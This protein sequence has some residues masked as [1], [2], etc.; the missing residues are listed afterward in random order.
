MGIEKDIRFTQKKIDESWKNE[1]NKHAAAP[2]PARQ[3]GTS[4][5]KPS[6][7]TSE[8]SYFM[9]LI[10]SLGMQALIQMGAVEDPA[11]RSKAQDFY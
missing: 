5:A 3:Q 4:A 7:A 6:S 11:S 9:N 8:T 2:N 1:I 10:S